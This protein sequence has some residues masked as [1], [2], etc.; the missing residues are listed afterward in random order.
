M[1]TEYRA[2]LDSEN[3]PKKKLDS[4]R[5]Q[6]LASAQQNISFNVKHILVFWFPY[7]KFSNAFSV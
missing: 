4:E 7:Y 3:V 5:P 1:V 6:K 2:Q